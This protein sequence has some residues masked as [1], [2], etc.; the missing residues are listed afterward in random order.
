[1]APDAAALVK[2]LVAAQAAEDEARNQIRRARAEQAAAIS[3]LRAAGLSSTQ[4]AHRVAFANGNVLSRGARKQ[5]AARLRQRLS[6]VTRGH[7][8]LAATHGLHAA[9]T[10]SSESRKKVEPMAK[11][12]KR[13]TTVETF[14]EPEEPDEVDESESEDDAEDQDDAD[15]EKPSRRRHNR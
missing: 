5:F 15:E 6:R 2:K 1:V 10:P 14:T 12:I 13:V 3:E 11:I 8:E 4:I 7:G 9:A